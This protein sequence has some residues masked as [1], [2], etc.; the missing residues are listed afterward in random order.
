MRFDR[1]K[2]REVI[3]LLSDAVV[4]PRTP[5][6]ASRALRA[7]Q[8]GKAARIGFLSTGTACGSQRP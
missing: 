5:P 3:M 2:R 8:A 1:L 4:T 7:P 6:L